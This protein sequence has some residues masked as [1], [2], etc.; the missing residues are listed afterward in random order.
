MNYCEHSESRYS[1]IKKHEKIS[2]GKGAFGE[3]RADDDYAIKVLKSKDRKTRESINNE[4]NVMTCFKQ[5]HDIVSLR[6]E[7]CYLEKINYRNFRVK[8]LMY[9]MQGDYNSIMGQMTTVYK[10]DLENVQF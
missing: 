1:L 2:I 7:G 3:I 10:K 4:I 5:H 8:L 9:R 6:S